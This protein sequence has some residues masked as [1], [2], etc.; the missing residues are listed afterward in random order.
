LL[1]GQDAIIDMSDRAFELF[2]QELVDRDSRL[3][4]E[5]LRQLAATHGHLMVEA[6][7]ES[8]PEAKPVCDA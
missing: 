3:A 1:E 4:A 7:L 8:R 6:A 5:T 2:V